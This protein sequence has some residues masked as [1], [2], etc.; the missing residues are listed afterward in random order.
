MR[1]PLCHS[2]PHLTQRAERRERDRLGGSW[3]PK[4]FTHV[5]TPTLFDGE[6]DL[7]KVRR[8]LARWGD[9]V[10]RKPIPVVGRVGR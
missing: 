4:W 5:E 7:D 3:A 1:P 9:D 10:H 6:L 8:W 2:P